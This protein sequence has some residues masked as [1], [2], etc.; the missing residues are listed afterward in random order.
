MAQLLVL[1]DVV[2]VPEI[3]NPG[4]GLFSRRLVKLDLSAH[5]PTLASSVNL[6]SCQIDSHLKYFQGF[7]QD[8]SSV[9]L[10]KFSNKLTNEPVACLVFAMTIQLLEIWP[11]SVKT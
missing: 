6:L 4:I 2:D 9:L 8:G 3:S 1:F 5:P 10:E 11:A 7:Y